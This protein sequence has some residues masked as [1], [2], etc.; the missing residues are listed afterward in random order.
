L[1]IVGNRYVEMN[2]W[3]IETGVLCGPGKLTGLVAWS[4]GATPVGTTIQNAW[5]N[6]GYNPTKPGAALFDV[7]YQ[8]LQPYTFL[9]FPTYGGGN[10]R[11]NPDG[12]GQMSDAYC[13]AARGDYAAAANLNLWG[14]YIWAHRVEKNGYYAGSF[15]GH[16]NNLPGQTAQ[17]APAAASVPTSGTVAS[18]LKQNSGGGWGAGANPF[19]DDGYLGWEAQA[20]LDWKLLENMSMQFAYSYWSLGPWFDQAYQAFTPTPAGLSGQ[21][22]MKGRAPIEAVRGAV[23]ITF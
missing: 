3:M 10:N 11:F 4:G 21:G 14:S 6:G 7:N 13:L 12:T 19:V 5:T 9:M 15:A 8:V 17:A 16:L 23:T 18:L 2:K 22:F 1:G 20:G